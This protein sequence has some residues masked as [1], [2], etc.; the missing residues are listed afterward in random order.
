MLALEDR[1][2]V[3]FPDELLTR[4]AFESVAAI[5]RSLETLGVVEAAA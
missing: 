2:D 3:E 1:F 5:R 4:K